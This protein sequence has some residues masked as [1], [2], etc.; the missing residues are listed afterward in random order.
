MNVSMYSF[1][2]AVM[3]FNLLIVIC[4]LFRKKSLAIIR[5]GVPTFI[6]VILFAVIRLVF[7]MEIPGYAVIVESN[8]VLP[9]IHSVLGATILQLGSVNISLFTAWI[10]VSVAVCIY[11]LAKLKINYDIAV[12]AY[13]SLHSHNTELESSIVERILAEKNKRCVV[14]IIKSPHIK[15]P[16]MTGIFQPTIY[17]PIIEYS[18][19][20]LYYIL[21]HELTHFFNW[22][23]LHK[24][25]V[26][27]ICAVL[28]WNPFVYIL[29]KDLSDAIE[30]KCDYT[31]INNL[32]DTGKY[33]YL[34]SLLEAC[35][36]Q[37][38]HENSMGLAF[39][40]MG[41]NI[42]IRQRF[43]VILNFKRNYINHRIAF[44][45]VLAGIL[46]MFIGSFSFIVQ[47]G[48]RAPGPPNDA[49]GQPVY[50]EYDDNG[51]IIIYFD[52]DFCEFIDQKTY[53]RQFSNIPIY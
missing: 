50:A 37:V 29:R 38:G 48:F 44:V 10:T 25:A 12:S 26:E 39:I 34:E 5:L 8:V 4:S 36:Y 14:K 21:L 17:M 11:K 13:S 9:F 53:D 27:V 22:D 6:L 28:W 16:M 51:S 3:W 49:Y 47:P 45:S 19:K 20:H 23:N 35:K 41:S 18:E 2:S 30:L 52:D 15:S 33:E 42:A 40:G 1:F 43:D 24:L 31:V 7:A 46:V 32:S